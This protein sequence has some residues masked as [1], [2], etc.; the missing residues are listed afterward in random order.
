[1]IGGG[2]EAKV[3]VYVCQPQSADRKWYA[4]KHGV[5]HRTALYS[6]DCGGRTVWETKSLLKSE[7]PEFLLVIILLIPSP[8][9]QE[10][11]IILWCTPNVMLWQIFVQSA[12]STSGVSSTS[13]L[14]TKGALLIKYSMWRCWKSFLM[15]WSANE[16]SCG[17]ISRWFFTLG[18]TV[19]SRK[20][21][22][23]R[24]SSTILSW[25]GSSCLL[26][27]SKTLRVCW[28]E[29]FSQTLGTLSHPW[30]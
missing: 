27:V 22:H 4:L 24:A 13:Y 30:K 28:K 16:E 9:N 8:N 15:S 5:P 11:C 7:P 3:I 20:G 12:F 14:Y 18:V 2:K 23:Y 25:P 10:I 6:T 26:A 1:M 19:F 29:S 21:H 17:G